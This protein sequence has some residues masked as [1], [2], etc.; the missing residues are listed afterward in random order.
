L[1]ISGRILPHHA[2]QQNPLEVLNKK[3]NP[4]DDIEEKSFESRIWQSIH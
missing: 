2:A 3:Q 4:I 1:K